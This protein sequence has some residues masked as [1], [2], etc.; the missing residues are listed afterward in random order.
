VFEIAGPSIG[1][2]R[3][4]AIST[5][6]IKNSRAIRKNWNENGMWGGFMRLKPH[7]NCVH[8]S[9]SC[10]IFFCRS[11]APPNRI[12]VIKAAVIHRNLGF[13][14]LISFLLEIKCTLYLKN[15]ILISIALS[16]GIVTLRPRS[17]SIRRRTRIR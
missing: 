4:R 5:S 9:F 17:V 2:D 7:S 1:Y 16:K 12:V 6:K 3:I 15:M 11:W 14:I 13:I 8:F 10:D